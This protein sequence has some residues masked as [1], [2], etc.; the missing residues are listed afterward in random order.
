MELNRQQVQRVFQYLDTYDHQTAR[1]D[2]FGEL[3]HQCFLASMPWL[4]SIGRG[5]ID[6]VI[7]EVNN[8]HKSRYWEELRFNDDKSILH[9]KGR[10]VDACACAL[11]QKERVNKSLCAYCCKRFQEHVFE[12]LIGQKVEVEITEAY[13]LGGQRC[14]TAIHIRD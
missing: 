13:M 7:E 4:E 5:H 3:G 10:V 11:A 12:Y 1:Q 8:Q 14:S 9:L 2:I 6:T